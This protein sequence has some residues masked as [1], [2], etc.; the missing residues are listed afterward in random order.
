MKKYQHETEALLALVSTGMSIC[1]A[2]VMVGMPRGTAQMRVHEA[3]QHAA[4]PARPTKWLY[5]PRPPLASIASTGMDERM[6]NSLGKVHIFTVGDLLNLTREELMQSHGFGPARVK[7]VY[8]VLE[9]AGYRCRNRTAAKEPKK[10]PVTIRDMLLAGYDL[11]KVSTIHRCRF[12]DVLAVQREIDKEREYA[13]RRL[14]EDGDGCVPLAEIELAVSRALAAR[15]LDGEPDKRRAVL[16]GIRYS[17]HKVCL[18][19]HEK[20]HCGL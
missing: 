11:A 3:R 6:V 20:N 7:E 19:F 12:S 18:S 15:V 14:G 10:E 17:P 16:H 4:M 13:E 1:R 8:R 5:V 2:A 9:K